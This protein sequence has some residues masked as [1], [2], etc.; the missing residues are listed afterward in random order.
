M[1]RSVGIGLDED[2]AARGDDASI[3]D[4]CQRTAVDLVGGDGATDGRRT[5][6]LPCAEGQRLG[7]DRDR[8]IDAGIVRGHH[9]HTAT[10]L[11][12]RIFVESGSVVDGGLGLAV[13]LVHRQD[14]AE[15]K[16]LGLFIVATDHGAL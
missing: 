12:V 6:G 14:H 9:G 3:R 7:N 15:T 8:G 10:C 1:D 11:D 16:G 5:G 13:D 4:R 2:V